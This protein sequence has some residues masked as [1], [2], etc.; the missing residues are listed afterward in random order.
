MEPI[1]IPVRSETRADVEESVE[2]V[3]T[4]TETFEAVSKRMTE[5]K[6]LGKRLKQE[7]LILQ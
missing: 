7:A 3:E 5:V 4:S 6:E 2:I 1:T